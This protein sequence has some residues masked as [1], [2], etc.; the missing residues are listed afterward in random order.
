MKRVNDIQ[1]CVYSIYIISD[2]PQVVEEIM[3][4]INDKGFKHQEING[5]K[6]KHED[7]SYEGLLIKRCV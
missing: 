4:R 6:R 3:Q 5:L 1:I 7:S 2:D